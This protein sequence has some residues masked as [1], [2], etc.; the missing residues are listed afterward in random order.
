[1]VGSRHQ[2][3]LTSPLRWIISEGMRR[4][5]LWLRRPPSSGP[6][7]HHILHLVNVP[8]FLISPRVALWTPSS[9]LFV[10]REKFKH[11]S[12][13]YPTFRK[14]ISVD[15]GCSLN[16]VFFPFVIFLNSAS[17]AAALVFYL[18]GMCTHT[19]TEGKQRQGTVR[20]IFKNSEKKHNI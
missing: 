3:F 14:S 15:T 1:M 18:S 6:P 7:P 12:S 2:L 20:N 4:P 11:G 19:D 9:P 10:I 16:I 17:S 8:F 5:L 13:R